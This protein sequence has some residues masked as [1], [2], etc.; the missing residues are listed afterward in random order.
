MSEH[1]I[2][3]RHKSFLQGRIYFN[4]HRSAVDCL[5]RDISDTGA[6]LT[7]SGPVII[8]DVADLYIPLKERMLRMRV[9]W[10]HG[11][12]AGVTF[13][14]AEEAAAQTATPVVAATA[15]NQDLYQ[16]VQYLEAEVASLR[17]IVRGLQTIH[18]TADVA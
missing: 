18:P 1:R 15:T 3:T 7:F 13:V 17:R 6:R 4:N 9:Q 5:I 10:R 8:P 2:T 12:E 14:P 11:D 16:R